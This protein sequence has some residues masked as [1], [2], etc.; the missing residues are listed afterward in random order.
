MTVEHV[1]DI[2]HSRFVQFFCTR[3]LVA[4]CGFMLALQS[5]ANAATRLTDMPDWTANSLAVLGYAAGFIALWVL[6]AHDPS[7]R[8]RHWMGWVLIAYWIARGS[9]SA[10][11]A[12]GEASH[13]IEWAE[14]ATGLWGWSLVAVLGG[15][16]IL[17][18]N[19]GHLWAE[20]DEGG[21]DGSDSG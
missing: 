8:F 4:F 15:A 13:I 9:G 17:A 11:R 21:R 10:V 19:P 16:M 7:V 2:M 14:E 12:P 6:F 3:P 20:Y 5:R 1:R 18:P